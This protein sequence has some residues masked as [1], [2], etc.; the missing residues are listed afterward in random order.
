MQR[1]AMSKTSQSPKQPS[2]E[3]QT[4]R[5]RLDAQS[6]NSTPQQSG[7]STPLSHFAARV[8]EDRASLSTSTPA[9]EGEDTEW[10]LNVPLPHNDVD[11]SESS[12]DDIWSTKATGRQT[13]GAFKRNKTA[14]AKP[15]KDDADADLSSASEGELSDSPPRQP[16]GATDRFLSKKGQRQVSDTASPLR[17]HAQQQDRKR[18]LP[19]SQLKGGKKSRKTM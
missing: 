6:R 12:E 5:R 9:K 18:K 1:A 13:F 4:K 10:V 8:M 19:H 15:A 3:P 16:K 14:P 2:S 7:D 17:Q 11:D